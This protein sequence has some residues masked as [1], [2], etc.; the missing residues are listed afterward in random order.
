LSP[1]L[2]H[3]IDAFVEHGNHQRYHESLQNLAPADAYFGCGQA[4]LKQRGRI[5]R[6]TI[7]TRHLLHRKSAAQSN[8]S[9]A[10]L[11]LSLRRHL[12]QNP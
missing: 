10:K 12:P 4:T 9:D 1:D 2:N 11:S 3:Q 6:Q 8:Q 5:K 7:E